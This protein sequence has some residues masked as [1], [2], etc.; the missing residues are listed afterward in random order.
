MDSQGPKEEMLPLTPKAVLLHST[1]QVLWGSERPCA[2]RAGLQGLT[3]AVA[4]ED[5][6]GLSAPVRRA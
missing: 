3:K 1:P 4:S 6:A 5:T 2:L